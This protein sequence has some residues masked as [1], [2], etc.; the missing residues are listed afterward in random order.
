M[1]R[2][3]HVKRVVTRFFAITKRACS[4]P[5]SAS[6]LRQP[7]RSASSCAL[8]PLSSSCGIKDS[9]LAI[10]E[11]RIISY[12]PCV[13]LKVTLAADSARINPVN[14][15]PSFVAQVW[16]VKFVATVLRHRLERETRLRLGAVLSAVTRRRRG[17]ELF[18][19]FA[20]AMWR[21]HGAAQDGRSHLRRYGAGRGI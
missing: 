11:R 12:N 10:T 15:R 9:A 13:C 1:K 17:D 6:P 5:Q 2:C 4:P 18:R 7:R 8:N 14:T 21:E 20:P 19:P 16:L 3:A